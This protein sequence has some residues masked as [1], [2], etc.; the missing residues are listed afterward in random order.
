M[1]H[2]KICPLGLTVTANN[3]EQRVNHQRQPGNC[4]KDVRTHLGIEND[5][6]L[7]SFPLKRKEGKPGNDR[8]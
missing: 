2:G 8:Q 1:N 6:L 5:S 4:G 3:A 7:E